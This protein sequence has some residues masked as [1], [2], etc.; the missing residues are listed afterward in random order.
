MTTELAIEYI[1]KRT[2]ELGYGE[3]Y[4]LRF[5]HYTI[6]PSGTVK[7]EGG[8]ALFLLIDPI[9]YIRVESDAGLFDLTE[10][11]TNELQYE[12]QGMILLTNYSPGLQHVQMI[13]VIL[14]TTE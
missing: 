12:H 5:R 4:R 13:Q 2:V 14:K 11:T 10:T 8:T 3:N 6:S 7:I 1:R 9:A